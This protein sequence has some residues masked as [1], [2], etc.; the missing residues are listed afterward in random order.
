MARLHTFL[1]LGNVP[2]C[3]CIIFSFIMEHLGYFHILLSVNNAAEEKGMFLF[4][5]IKNPKQVLLDHMVI[6][7]LIF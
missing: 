6:L 4:S 2:L 3:V 5:W 1:W 7:F